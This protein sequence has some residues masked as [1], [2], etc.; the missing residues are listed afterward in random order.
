MR[1]LPASINDSPLPTRRQIVT[2]GALA[3]GGLGIG[4][5]ADGGAA[6]GEISH[7]AEAIHQEPLIPASRTRIYRT[8][9]DAR[10]FERMVQLS[11]AA[12]EMA[13]KPKQVVLEAHAGGAFAAF[14]G[15]VTG[16]F[17]ELL[18][19]ELIVQAWR[20][21]SWSPGIFSIARFQL[22][23][24]DSGTKILFDHTGFPL[25]EAEH[26]AQG[27]HDNYWNPLQALLQ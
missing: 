8:L 27:W 15:Y 12:K 11:A 24:Q 18:A 19:D 7:S 21:A 14:G 20:A 25:G 9:T 6:G 23:E 26:L 17:I 5:A 4:F 10:Q 2:A 3:L 1:N 13:I 22:I 16:R